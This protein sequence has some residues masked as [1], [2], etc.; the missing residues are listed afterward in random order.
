M[1]FL[2][3]HVRLLSLSKDVVAIGL[4]SVPVVCGFHSSAIMDKSWNRQNFG[5]RKWLQNNKT[6]YPP[7]EAHEEPRKGVSIYFL[8]V[9]EVTISILN[10]L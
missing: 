5:P 7:Q 8:I 1:N 4:K 3:K 6:I 9:Q 10:L 2:L